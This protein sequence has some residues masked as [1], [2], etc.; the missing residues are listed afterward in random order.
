MH[1][2]KRDG[3]RE[4]VSFDKIT[5]RLRALC[6]GLDPAHVDPVVVARKVCLGVADGVHTSALDVLA[7]ETA[8][9]HSADHPGYGRLAARVAVTNLRKQTPGTFSERARALYEYRDAARGCAAPLLTKETYDVIAAHAA[10]LDAAIEED[11]DLELDYFGFKTLERSYLLRMGG[12]V[13]E[14]PQHLLMRV[15]VGIHGADVPAAI[16]TYR[17]MAAGLFTHASPTLFNAGTPLGQLSSCFLVTLKADSIDG[18]YDT[19][20]DCALISKSAGGIG[21]AMHKLRATGAYIAGTN[22]TSNGLVPLLRVFNNSARYVDQGGGKRKGTIAVYL[23]PW[24]ADV[25]AFLDLRKNHGAEEMRARDLF[26]ALWVPDL[27]MRRVESNGTWSLMCPHE[28]P[29]LA[30]AHGEEFERLYEGYEGAG[31]FRRQV[32]ARELWEALLNAQVETGGPFMLYKD[33]CNRKSNQKNLG[34]IPCS[35]LCTEVVQ[36]SAPDEV[37][38]C[39]LASIAL[40]RFVTPEGAFDHAR[41]AE[42]TRVVTRNLNRVIEVTRYPVVEAQRSNLRH[43]PIGIG[44]QGL[45]DTFALMRLPFE[46]ID[47]ARLNKDIFETLYH[48]ALSASCELA[49]ELGA[50]AS[51]AGSPASEGQLQFDLWGVTP[52]SGRWDW[53]ALKR[54]IARFGLRNSLLLAP[55]PTASTSQILGNN[56]CFEPFTSNVYV[57]RT[58]A[59]EFLVVNPHLVRELS[60]RGLW[61][62]QM[63]NALIAHN[64]SVQRIA[65]VPADVRAVFKTVWEIKGKALVDL[66]IA[67]GPFIDQSQSFNVHMPDV[68]HA[69]LSSLHFYTWKGGLK[70]GMY[71]LRTQAA[72]DATKFTVDAALAEA[73]TCSRE[74]GCTSCSA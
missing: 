37:S 9:Y 51:Y 74:E 21:L 64:G 47:A 46:S 30:E 54:R 60:E 35:N 6:D 65:G 62:A 27:F 16:E 24:H 67:R 72:T 41:L 53:T 63:K 5:A 22:G 45:A 18:I 17:L 15:A 7:A 73:A 32:P 10:E 26:S 57:R 23:E 40:N 29:G 12:R 59:G 28:C 39:N 13:A 19:L 36:F 56:E 50:Y 1:V 48:A 43:R 70:T 61:N 3:T 2:I 44:V 68:T 58:L 66:A 42:V 52:D 69:K 71:Y 34:T 25:F 11:R 14:R 49:E 31:R 55:M 4:P 8:A 20:K 33:A 38:V